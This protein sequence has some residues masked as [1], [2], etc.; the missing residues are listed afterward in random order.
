M[1]CAATW[2]AAQ[3]RGVWG[4]GDAPARL[5]QH[6]PG[7]GRPWLRSASQG[8]C[9]GPVPAEEAPCCRPQTAL[10]ECNGAR[11]NA[12]PQ[13][14]AQVDYD[15]HMRLAPRGTPNLD[16]ALGS[17]NHFHHFRCALGPAPRSRAGL[18]RPRQHPICTSRHS[19]PPGLLSD[20]DVADVAPGPTVLAGTGASP[21][22]RTSC[23]AA[24]T[25][26][27]T[28][29]CCQWLGGAPRSTWTGEQRGWGPQTR[30]RSA[31]EDAT[32]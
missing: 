30:A 6:A 7:C 14:H 1:M 32:V 2:C 3:W 12:K 9:S 19:G 28:P 22:W 8:A 21:A 24:R 20:Q 29:A 5:A 11:A 23:G 10:K 15:Y 26:R 25:R 27:P 17:I 18:P 4:P 31:P 13:K 16:P